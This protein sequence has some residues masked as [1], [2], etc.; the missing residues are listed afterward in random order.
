[1]DLLDGVRNRSG[2]K[3]GAVGDDSLD[4]FETLRNI[5]IGAACCLRIPLTSR[6]CP[7]SSLTTVIRTLRAGTRS[8]FEQEAVIQGQSLFLR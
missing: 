7:F 5:T 3:L 1:M 6:E 2:T 4:F 8:D